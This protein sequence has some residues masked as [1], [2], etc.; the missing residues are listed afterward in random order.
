MERTFPLSVSTYQTGI[1]MKKFKQYTEGKT[2]KD[3]PEIKDLKKDAEYTPIQTVFGSHSIPN[4]EYESIRTVFGNPNR[5]KSEYASIR[6][7][8]GKHSEEYITEKLQRSHDHNVEH[9]DMVKHY[10]NYN[11]ADKDHIRDYTLASRELNMHLH[12]IGSEGHDIMTHQDRDSEYHKNSVKGMDEVMH[13][14]RT[15]KPMNVWTGVSDQHDLHKISAHQGAH[16]D[17][18]I[19]IIHHA[20]TSSSINKNVATDFA[21][22]KIASQSTTGGTE[23]HHKVETHAHMLKIHVPKGHPGAYVDHHSTVKGEHEFILPR[24]TKLHVHH[25]PT[26]ITKH[27]QTYNYETGTN[28]HRTQHTHIWRA[29]I[30]K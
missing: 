17:K 13:R 14:H 27:E 18:P 3:K 4:S 7:K 23:R 22:K 2:F 5:K 8:F 21:R 15:H 24:G 11:D 19:K 12:R 10:N 6:T 16:G 26:T 30:V 28:E 1:K 20:Y 29:R 25:K 9:E